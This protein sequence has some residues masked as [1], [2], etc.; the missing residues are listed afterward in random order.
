MLKLGFLIQIPFLEHGRH[1]IE[2][3]DIGVIAFDSL[4][5]LRQLFDNISQLPRWFVLHLNFNWV[6][7]LLIWSL[8]MEFPCFVTCDVVLQVLVYLLE[9]FRC[10]LVFIL[11]EYFIIRFDHRGLYFLRH[12]FYFAFGWV[13]DFKDISQKGTVVEAADEW[14]QIINLP[15][16]DE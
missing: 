5:V 6:L 14:G 12:Y 13:V 11:V 4:L 1:A 2:H 10:E 15:I 8:F 16:S 7:L 9:N 3:F